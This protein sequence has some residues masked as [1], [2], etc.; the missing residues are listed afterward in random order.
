[1][2]R[3]IVFDRASASAV[4]VRT[5]AKPELRQEPIRAGNFL[6]LAVRA[7][8]SVAVMPGE[9]PGTAILMRVL[10]REHHAEPVHIEQNQVSAKPSSAV[11]DKR[12]EKQADSG[13]APSGF[14]GLSDS[15]DMDSEPEKPKKWW[16][17]L[18]D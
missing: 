6:D 3:F 7:S 4:R 18:L 13:L 8:T 5:G 17:K 1:M 12:Y 9:Q 16:Q 15:V 2:G 10:S 14:L 11:E